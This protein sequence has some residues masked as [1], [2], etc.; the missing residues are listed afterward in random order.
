[1]DSLTIRGVEGATVRIG[2][3]TTTSGLAGSYQLDGVSL[4]THTMD[5]IS[6]AHRPFSTSLAV[7]SDTFRNVL[8]WRLAPYLEF[9]TADEWGTTAAWV[10]LDGDFP[11][12]AW[13]RFHGPLSV[14]EYHSGFSELITP[15]ARHFFFPAAVGVAR[16]DV[17]LIDLAGH[18]GFF[19]CLPAWICTEE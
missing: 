17:E 2:E 11:N 13:A 8:L 14:R 15:I 10:D 16:I 9:L 1:M 19:M 12:S 3:W 18:R 6:T 5:V 7:E 4:G